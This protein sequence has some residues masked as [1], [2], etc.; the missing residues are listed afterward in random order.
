MHK[1]VAIYAFWD[2]SSD[3]SEVLS[4]LTISSVCVQVWGKES[5]MVAVLQSAHGSL[6]ENNIHV[7]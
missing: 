1:R 7:H 3:E 2:A 6:Q 4:K 5:S